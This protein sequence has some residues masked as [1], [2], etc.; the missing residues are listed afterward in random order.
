MQDYAVVTV[1][2]HALDLPVS[3]DDCLH[4]F[5]VRDT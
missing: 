4:G 2:D 5:S 3:Y 1:P